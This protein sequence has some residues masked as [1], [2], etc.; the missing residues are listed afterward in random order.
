LLLWLAISLV[1]AMALIGS[2]AA[3]PPQAIL[4]GPGIDTEIELNEFVASFYETNNTD[5]V[6]SSI[7]FL[8]SSDI[9]DDPGSHGS[10]IGFY[11]E[12]FKNNPSKLKVWIEEI[13]ALSNENSE[14][15]FWVALWMSN[16]IEGSRYL[17]NKS[18]KEK[19]E[20][21]ETLTGFLS[22]EPWDLK[23]IMP[24][25]PEDNDI[26]WGTF[27]ASGNPDYIV[28]II[29]AATRYDEKDSLNEFVTAGTAKWS[30]SANALVS[31]IVMDT[32]LSE[33]EKR[34]LKEKT[35]I[36]DILNKASDTN[37]PQ[38]IID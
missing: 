11:S 16:T 19:G 32:L 25:S 4:G 31:E 27:Y 38:S 36:Q 26:L 8:D 14:M 21:K 6:S 9:L 33:K 35:I 13:D 37:G 1:G 34:L 20:R 10:T 24:Q 12:V 17:K 3:I 22:N 18:E 29:D 2:M 7:T 23:N 15:V 28:P 30:L 5:L